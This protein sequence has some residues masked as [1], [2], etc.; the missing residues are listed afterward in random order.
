MIANF[1]IVL[2]EWKDLATGFL[3]TIW[4]CALAGVLSLMLAV[5]VSMLLVSRRRAVR[6]PVQGAVDVLRAIPFLM[7]LFIVYYCLPVV[8]IRLSSWTCG[9]AALVGYNTAYF[10]EILRGAWAHLP[11]EQ[12]EAGRAYGY[13]GLGLYRR[14]ILPQILI[15]S[16]P[17]LGNQMI[18][19]IKNSA[20]LMVITIPELTFMANQVQAIHFVPFETLLVAVALYWTICSAIEWTVRGMDRVAVV[21]GHE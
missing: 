2:G 21:R 3:N 10:A 17:I 12:E 14:I 9:L 8:N 16:G 4:I 5:F 20:F 19:L 15:A 11:H 6:R 7:L 18:T 1:G 13:S